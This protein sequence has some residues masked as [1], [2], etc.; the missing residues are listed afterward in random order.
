MKEGITKQVFGIILGVVLLASLVSG[1]SFF[2]WKSL[3]GASAKDARLSPEEC[4]DS[5]GGLNYNVLGEV[6]LDKKKQDS[7][8]SA[9][10]LRE[11][12]CKYGKSST[13]ISSVDYKCPNGCSNGA[14]K[15]PENIKA[16]SCDADSSC[17]ISSV[18][19]SNRA[20]IFGFLK[21]GGDFNVNGIS[22]LEGKV[23]TL[24]D[25][26]LG[27]YG[28]QEPPVLRIYQANGNKYLNIFSFAK[29]NNGL[30]VDEGDSSF[31]GRVILPRLVANSNVT[32][33]AYLCID[34]QGVV[35]RSLI[36]CR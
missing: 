16:N 31:E 11:Y 6:Y 21:V 5:D 25:V 9:T 7:C 23:T 17:E 36:A 20:D 22:T 18:L 34:S 33:N 12:Y 29:L 35:F 28:N 32:G 27:K 10:T 26:E 19:V 13:T 30:N 2:D 1:F 15:T 8:L 24:S 4:E 14:C 3:F